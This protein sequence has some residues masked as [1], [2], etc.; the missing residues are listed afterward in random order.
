MPAR[1]SQ[2]TQ[3]LDFK[4]KLVQSGKKETIDAQLK[5]IKVCPSPLPRVYDNHQ[6]VS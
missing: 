6:R 1:V 3:R 5:R 4:E 2:T